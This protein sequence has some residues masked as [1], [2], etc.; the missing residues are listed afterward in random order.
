M[1]SCFPFGI[2]CFCFWFSS[3]TFL[4]P[5]KKQFW[6]LI[7]KRWRQPQL[8][9]TLIKTLNR[10]PVFCVDCFRIF[11]IE[12]WSMMTEEI[13]NSKSKLEWENYCRIRSKFF[14]YRFLVW[15]FFF[16]S[17][18]HETFSPFFDAMPPN[19]F[20]SHRIVSTRF[21]RMQIFE[22]LILLCKLCYFSRH[23]EIT[24]SSRLD[25]NVRA[26]SHRAFRMFY[27]SMLSHHRHLR[28]FIR[29]R[30]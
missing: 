14:I 3:N 13:P 28:R 11:H 24:L 16:W 1:D 9:L 21:I 7:I 29:F 18:L 10:I 5:A 4:S 6:I 30:Y 8:E 17:C 2:F 26:R 20:F 23:C 15:F 19:R 25:A 12:L 22:L 27:S